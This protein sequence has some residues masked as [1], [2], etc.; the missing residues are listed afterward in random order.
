MESKFKAKLSNYSILLT[1]LV[2]IVGFSVPYILFFRTDLIRTDNQP[3]DYVKY[4]FCAILIITLILTFLLHPTKYIINKN[5]III[6]NLLYNKLISSEQI[7]SVEKINYPQLSIRMRL[8]ASG[9]VWGFFGLF[10]SSTYGNINMQTTN[11]N[12]LVLIKT[13]NK[14]ITII[15]PENS[16]IF[17]NEYIEILRTIK[18]E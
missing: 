15:S 6:K 4:L 13:K 16:Q 5:G 8:F 17:L 10:R 18:N 11:F 7:I 12:N 1:I 9:G 2:N 14:K 3:P